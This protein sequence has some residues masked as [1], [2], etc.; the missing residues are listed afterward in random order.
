MS[1]L[2]DILYF[3]TAPLSKQGKPDYLTNPMNTL[4][5]RERLVAIARKDVGQIETSRNHGPAIG[6]F[7]TATTYPEGYK[8]REPYCAAAGCY[9]LR[10]WLLDPEVLHA[11]KL[12][13]LT[14]EEWRCKSPSA[15]GWID[16]AR[17]KGIT[18]LPDSP[19]V[20]LHTGDIVIYD[21][22]H[23]GVVF[24][25]YKDRIKT[26]EANTGPPTGSQRDGDGIYEKDRPR[27]IARCFIRLL[28]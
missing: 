11:L 6:K 2:E 7:W 28:A 16:W 21:F 14:A 20:V 27:E 13:P 3:F 8:N 12:T 5:L 17:G 15:Y 4:E 9:W 25:D 10:Q 22:S 23:W 1:I 19:D 18:V 24:D 26:I